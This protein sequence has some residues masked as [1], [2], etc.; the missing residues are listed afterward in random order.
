MIHQN[1]VAVKYF[2]VVLHFFDTRFIIIFFST[3]INAS[4]VYPSSMNYDI[5][6]IIVLFLVPDSLNYSWLVSVVTS[7]YAGMMSSVLL[8]EILS[9][10]SQFEMKGLTKERNMLDGIYMWYRW[11]ILRCSVVSACI[12]GLSS[13]IKH[14]PV[15]WYSL[16]WRSIDLKGF[17]QKSKIGL[18][19]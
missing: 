14:S 10:L 4:T 15:L 1:G 11:G 8:I 6:F 12:L 18:I 19:T 13:L 17:N 2:W 16:S 3:V 9:D 5:F 7:F